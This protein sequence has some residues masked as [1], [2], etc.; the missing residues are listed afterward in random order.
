MENRKI[1]IDQTAALIRN[2]AERRAGNYIALKLPRN[3]IQRK[4]TEYQERKNTKKYQERNIKKAN[5]GKNAAERSKGEGTKG[6]GY[7]RRLPE[8][9]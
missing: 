6:A 7:S 2:H 9:S 4:K 5:G 3:T 8:M 1:Q